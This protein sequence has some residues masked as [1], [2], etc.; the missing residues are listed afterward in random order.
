R[1]LVDPD[2]AGHVRTDPD[3]DVAAHRLDATGQV[4]V[5]QADCAVHGLDVAADAAACADK[6]AAVHR[7]HAVAHGGPLADADAAVDGGQAVGADVVGGADAAVHGLGVLHDGAAF[8]GDAPVHRVH[9]A[10][11][12][13]RLGRDAAVDLADVL[14]RQHRLRA[15]QRKQEQGN[16]QAGA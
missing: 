15:R 14:L 8:D 6:D 2:A 5:N 9:V 12:A 16:G 4:D 13:A 1:G 11:G 3:G 7:F 10:V